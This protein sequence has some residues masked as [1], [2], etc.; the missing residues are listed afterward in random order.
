MCISSNLWKRFSI[1]TVKVKICEIFLI[2]KQIGISYL[3]KF[4]HSRIIL[5]F[6]A[7]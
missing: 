5:D 3:K 6:T 7:C 1:S 2:N 4:V